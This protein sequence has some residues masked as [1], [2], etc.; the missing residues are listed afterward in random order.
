MKIRLATVDI[1]RDSIVNGEGI[2]AVI[3]TQGCP[4]NCFGCHNPETHS[5]NDG[6]LV[7]VED[8]IKKI[9]S[10]E[11]QDGITFVVLLLNIVRG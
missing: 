7:D 9:D 8:V 10:L 2:R 11:G 1:E 3:W 5:L 6:Y 4:H